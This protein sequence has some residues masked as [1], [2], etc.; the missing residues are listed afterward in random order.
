MHNER[1]NIRFDNQITHFHLQYSESKSFCEDLTEGKF[2]FPIIHAVNNQ[3]ND[4]QV[5]REYLIVIWQS[6]L[7]R[8]NINSYS[9]FRF[10]RFPDI[11][12]QR[13]K[14]VEVKKYCIRLLEKLGS[15]KYTRDIL[16]SLDQQAREEVAKLGPN[17]YMNNLL[18]DLL[19]WN[20]S[21]DEVDD[22]P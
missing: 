6:L 14:D 11:L 12:R 16:L 22:Q 19:T 4:R 15:F 7:K 13:T 20:A 3:T 17:T 18:N 2:S 5:L 10:L 9:C 21:N 1:T 8:F